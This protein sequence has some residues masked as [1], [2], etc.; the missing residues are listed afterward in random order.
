MAK[1]PALP[2]SRL[3]PAARAEP[4]YGQVPD[5]GLEVFSLLKCH[6]KR[7]YGL[8]VDLRDLPAPV[9]DEVH[10]L[11]LGSQVVSGGTVEQVRVRHEPELLEQLER[12]VDGGHIDGAGGLPYVGEYFLRSSVLQ[13][14]NGLEHQ[15][16]LRR[17][18][19]SARPKRVVPLLHH[20]DECRAAGE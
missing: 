1:R 7:P 16:A 4:E 5:V 15:L 3:R 2:G 12:P 19:V 20:A 10:V 14:R 6:H 9:A 17:D 13:P 11:G 8:L 18:A